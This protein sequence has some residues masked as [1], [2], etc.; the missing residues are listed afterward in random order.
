MG[1]L[2]P[3]TGTQ[4]AA[5]VICAA[6]IVLLA[7]LLKWTCLRLL[8]RAFCRRNRAEAH[9]RPTAFHFKLA[10]RLYRP[11]LNADDAALDEAELSLPGALVRV[12]VASASSSFAWTTR[13]VSIGAEGGAPTRQLLESLASPRGTMMLPNENEAEPDRRLIS[14]VGTQ[15]LLLRSDARGTV[16]VQWS[17]DAAPIFEV[18]ASGLHRTTLRAAPMNLLEVRE[19][20]Q[21]RQQ[22]M[23]TLASVQ[24][25]AR[26]ELG[27]T[28]SEI[29]LKLQKQQICLKSVIR[30]AKN[31]D[32]FEDALKAERQVAALATALH[33]CNRLLTEHGLSE[34]HI[35][36]EGQSLD[37]DQDSLNLAK[38]RASSVMHLLVEQLRRQMKGMGI[39]DFSSQLATRAVG[40]N[41]LVKQGETL[42]SFKVMTPQE[43]REHT[44]A[45][46]HL[47]VKR[48][49]R[50]K[51]PRE[52]WLQIAALVRA[53]ARQRRADYKSVQV[54]TLA[55]L[56][57]RPNGGQTR[58]LNS[59]KSGQSSPLLAADVEHGSDGD[60]TINDAK[61]GDDDEENDE[62]RRPS[63]PLLHADQLQR[64]VDALT[65]RVHTFQAISVQLVATGGGAAAHTKTVRRMRTQQSAISRSPMDRGP[66]SRERSLPHAN[67]PAEMSRANPGITSGTFSFGRERSD[68]HEQTRSRANSQFLSAQANSRA[69]GAPIRPTG[70]PSRAGPNPRARSPPSGDYGV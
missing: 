57:L 3:I 4:A 2:A 11:R 21:E 9:K 38:R 43:A 58:E 61:L 54:A 46:A 27:G 60:R 66:L 44:D 14:G 40:G 41:Q 20:A 36:I 24:A 23:V 45:R 48:E 10:L 19:L 64:D 68:S 56:I 30:F 70:T 63:T 37:F 13:S 67:S 59:D 28:S 53:W 39:S 7:V 47:A 49:G 32:G 12:F 50:A 34:L 31:A 16:W 22:F 33:A 69:A 8:L 42:I 52:R 15:P 65:G 62:W 25:R 17:G 1:H 6:A 29:S 26:M 5:I 55:P 51:I 18:N 35:I